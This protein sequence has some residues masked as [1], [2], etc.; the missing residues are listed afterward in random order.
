M[1]NRVNKLRNLPYF[2]WLQLKIHFNNL[3]TSEYSMIYIGDT[4][5]R[6]KG[7]S[8][9]NLGLVYSFH[10]ESCLSNNYGKQA[11]TYKYIW[12]VVNYVTHRKLLRKSMKFYILTKIIFCFN[13]TLKYSKSKFSC[14]GVLLRLT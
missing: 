1:L 9:V 12:S 4:L 6:A 8:Q 3:N 11:A 2:K 7:K 13:V 5:K 14:L 10:C